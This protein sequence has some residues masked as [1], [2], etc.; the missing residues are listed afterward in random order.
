MD[1][2]RY[3]T[4]R[5]RIARQG[6]PAQVKKKMK[7]IAIELGQRNIT[8]KD[9]AST[10]FGGKS[11]GFIDMMDK[12][13]MTMDDVVMLQAYS[14][15]IIDRDIKAAEFI[16]DTKGEKPATTVDMSV[17]DKSPIEQMS[18][19]ELKAYSELLKANIEL[20]KREN[21]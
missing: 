11:R 4:M 8:L 15:A 7:Q 20:S 13:G 14:K 3:N 9:I 21:D 19:E 12:T 6:T 10:D 17:S 5:E 1:N 16:R 2:K 18:D